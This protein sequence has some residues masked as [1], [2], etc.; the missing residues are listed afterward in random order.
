MIVRICGGKYNG[1][2]L[3]IPPPDISRPTSTKVRAAIF[4]MLNSHVSD[5]DQKH[6]FLDVCAGSG[7]MGL[8]WDF[9]H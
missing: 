5:L 2:K 6:S 1:K 7:I 3:A 8:E 9:T 4:N